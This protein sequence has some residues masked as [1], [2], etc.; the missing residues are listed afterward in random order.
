MRTPANT[1]ATA[2][3]KNRPLVDIRLPGRILG[4]VIREQDGREATVERARQPFGRTGSRATRSRATRYSPRNLS[5]DQMVSVIR[6]FS[7]FRTR[8]HRRGPTLRPRRLH[9]NDRA[10]A[11]GVAGDDVRWPSPPP[12]SPPRPSPRRSRR[13][14]SRRFSRHPTEVQR[15]S[16]QR[17]NEI[18]GLVTL[19]E[20]LHTDRERADNEAQLKGW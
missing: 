17:R 8:Q 18:A 16:I 19:R 14:T 15:Q 9:Q 10:P 7:F 11:G 13:R 6:A 20:T 1:A 5:N 4:D 3:E 2:A 12:A